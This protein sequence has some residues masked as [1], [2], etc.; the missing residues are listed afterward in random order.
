MKKSQFNFFLINT[1]Q[2]THIYIQMESNTYKHFFIKLF[3]KSKHT[4][5][6]IS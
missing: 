5:K 4:E 2:T 3:S 6:Y 1:K